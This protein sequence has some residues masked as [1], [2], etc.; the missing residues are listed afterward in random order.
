MLRLRGLTAAV[1]LAAAVWSGSR[2]YGTVREYDRGDADL[3]QMYKAVESVYAPGPEETKEYPGEN[4][5]DGL[6][7]LNS[8]IAAW[9]RIENTAIDYP[10]MHTPGEPDFYLS[11]GFDKEPSVYGMIYM[12]AGCSLDES[13][14]NRILYGHHMKN[15]A[16]FAAL[17]EYASGEYREAHPVILFD[18]PEG[19]EYYEVFAAMSLSASQMEESLTEWLAADTEE[20][21]RNLTA[22]AMKQSFYSKKAAPRWP[23]PL[24]TLIT[25]EY[26]KK[27]GRF[28]VLAGKTGKRN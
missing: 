9:I 11:H 12:D 19:T 21:Y 16:M 8:D 2:L 4:R 3:G 7:K 26:T 1:F 27:D 28:L 14:K 25:C 17:P 10:V 5:F 24:L 18:T 6:Q 22:Y 20:A 13:C 15:G 23:E